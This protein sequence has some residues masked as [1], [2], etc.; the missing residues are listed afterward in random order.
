MSDDETSKKEYNSEEPE[1]LKFSDIDLSG[2][3]SYAQYLRWEI[4]ERL[5][6][7]KG[8]IFA[9]S[10]PNRN[11]QKICGSIFNKLYNYLENQPCEVYVAP[12]E[13]RLANPSNPDSR[14]FT[15]VQPD[16]CV[17]CDQSKLDEKGCIGAPDVVV[18]IL[19]PGNNSKEMRNKYEVYQESGVK[20]Y[21][22]V[23]PTEK[24]IL[25]YILNKEGL[26]EPGRPLTGGDVLISSVLPGF[27]LPADLVFKGVTEQT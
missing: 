9:M 12:F 7:I 21:W 16:V 22:V 26:F 1:I 4:D 11:H 5:E 8:K 25:P 23:V 14:V 24:I 6:L 17:I 10:A 3:Y 15:V 2:T 19:S 13:V 18:E 20:E 27:G